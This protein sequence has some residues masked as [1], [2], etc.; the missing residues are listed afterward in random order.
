MMIE[1][2]PIESDL[3]FYQVKLDNGQFIGEDDQIEF[4][5]VEPTPPNGGYGWVCALSVFLVNSHTW[6]VNSV[7]HQPGHHYLEKG[8]T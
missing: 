3:G 2:E 8:L 4:T 1:K 6:G 5:M 7:S